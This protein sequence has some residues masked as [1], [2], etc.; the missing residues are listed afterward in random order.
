MLILSKK[1]FISAPVA[2]AC[3]LA[4]SSNASATVSMP[5]GTYIGLLGGIGYSGNN[6]ASQKG[7]AFFSSSRGGPLYVNANGDVSGNSG[8]LGLHVGYAWSG[9]QHSA[10]TF[11]PA[12]ELEGYYLHNTQS[13]HLINP[14]ARLPEHNFFDSFP[15][16]TGV[17][18]VNAVFTFK[19]P[20]N[21]RIDPY[22][23]IGIGGAHVSISGA[24]S[25]QTSPAEPGVNHFN[26]DTGASSWLFAAQAKAGLHIGLST[27]WSLFGEY[28]LLYLP[29][30]SY[31]FGSTQY[32]T[33]VP[34][35]RWSAGITDMF[36]NMGVAGLEYSV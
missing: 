17:Y 28:R 21:E 1:L 36:Y 29:S 4:F 2:L 16:S 7:T 35:S 27:H 31:T 22:V 10:W 9:W 14:T 24:N 6:A 33:H 5:N 26:S 20:A 23:G 8:I 30:S 13:G 11:I 25:A 12:A 18:L 3:F 32:P 15:M 19:N 34:T